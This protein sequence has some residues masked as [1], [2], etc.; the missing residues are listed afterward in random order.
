M[1]ASG[2]RKNSEKIYLNIMR[3]LFFGI[4]VNIADKWAN[5]LLF[6]IH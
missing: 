3:E 5:W 2:Q 4:I 6:Y 1:I